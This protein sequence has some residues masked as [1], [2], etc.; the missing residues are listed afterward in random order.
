MFGLI[1]TIMQ[2]SVPVQE[3]EREPQS[4]LEGADRSSLARLL[5]ID[6]GAEGF[7]GFPMGLY[8]LRLRGDAAAAG[9]AAFRCR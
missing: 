2:S 3:E 1:G 7:C 9:L 5:P 4:R 6:A 8:D